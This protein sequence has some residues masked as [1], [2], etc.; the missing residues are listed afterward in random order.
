MRQSSALL[1]MPLRPRPPEP[2]VFVRPTARGWQAIFFGVF[3]LVA[4]LLVGTTQIYQLAYALAGLLLV[5]LVLGLFFSQGLRYARRIPEGERLTAA[6]PSRV[7][8]VVSNT[9]RTKSPDVEIVDYISKRHLFQTP[10]L[11]GAE[12]RK[13]RE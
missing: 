8:L 5:A 2:R 3:S 7:E 13:V 10:P 1:K 6:R 4:A 9:S 11:R 12:T